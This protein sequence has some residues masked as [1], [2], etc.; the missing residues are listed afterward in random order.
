MQAAMLETFRQAAEEPLYARPLNKQNRADRPFLEKLVDEYGFRI[1]KGRQHRKL[2]GMDPAAIPA[3]VVEK[4]G[5]HFHGVDLDANGKL[6]VLVA[7]NR[8]AGQ[9]VFLYDLESMPEQLPEVMP[10][11]EPFQLSL[12][13]SSVSKGIRPFP[14][15]RRGAEMREFMSI[16]TSRAD[17]DSTMAG[18]TPCY[19]G[20]F[21]FITDQKGRELQLHYRPAGDGEKYQIVWQSP[22]PEG[23]KWEMPL[24]DDVS[25]IVWKKD[26]TGTLKYITTH[27]DRNGQRQPKTISIPIKAV[28]PGLVSF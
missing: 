8:Q 9:D 21:F 22:L 5:W 28:R 7:R 27:I 3:I 20:F 11:P 1:G 26:E 18:Y 24:D 17:V 13:N 10:A 12:S 23:E 19:D 15:E 2:E 4:G 25:F 16:C 6:D 14:R